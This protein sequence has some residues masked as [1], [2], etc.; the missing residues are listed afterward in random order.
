MHLST[1]R[2][3]SPRTPGEG[4]RV[5]TVRY[6][7]RG[8]RREDYARLDYFDVWFPLL[9]PSPALIRWLTSKREPTDSVWAAFVRRY[10]QEMRRTDAC[11]AI[12]LLAEFARRTPI[13]VGCYCENETR[14]HR[15][16]L[17]TLIVAHTAAPSR[18]ARRR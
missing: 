17:R 1:Y 5:G 8:V 10:K 12:A 16:I 18:R 2:A 11:Q 4:L 14:C 15:S 3:G 13:A 7:P 6:V 9:A